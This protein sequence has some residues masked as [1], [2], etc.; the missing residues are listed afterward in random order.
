MHLPFDLFAK[1]RRHD[2]P[3]FVS[4]NPKREAKKQCRQGGTIKLES[5]DIINYTRLRN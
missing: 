1:L 5:R 3:V 4:D 2:T